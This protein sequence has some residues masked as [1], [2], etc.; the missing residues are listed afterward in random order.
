MASSPQE[1]V[2]GLVDSLKADASAVA[3]DF[4]P[5]NYLGGLYTAT[6]QEV[7]ELKE[8]KKSNARIER[9]LAKSQGKSPLGGELIAYPP[10]S[11]PQSNLRDQ[12][13]SRT[14]ATIPRGITRIDFESGTV[15][16]PHGRSGKISQSL[17]SLEASTVKSL[18]IHA[19]AHLNV[20]FGDEDTGYFIEQFQ[21]EKFPDISV[22]T[23][24]LQAYYPTEVK[25]YASTAPEVTQPSGTVQS[26]DY[27]TW[28]TS[29]TPE[30]PGFTVSKGSETILDMTTSTDTFNSSPQPY[31]EAHVKQMNGMDWTVQNKGNAAAEFRIYEKDAMIP[32]GPVSPYEY[33]DWTP[34]TGYGPGRAPIIEPGESKEFQ[35]IE[36]P[37]HVLQV[38]G[39]VPDGA[40]ADSTTLAATMIGRAP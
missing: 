40:S 6:K 3:G 10:G 33:V 2:E 26:T 16:Q 18:Y 9:A 39:T 23:V 29:V 13:T 11:K 32:H 37:H 19:T 35:V 25:V 15:S 36:N 1:A 12:D 27:T 5:A 20:Y 31:K 24:D 28:N 30:S 7:A 21:A 8:I 14:F 22:K 38:R 17:N 4:N 34:L